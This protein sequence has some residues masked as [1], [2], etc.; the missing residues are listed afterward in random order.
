MNK[1]EAEVIWGSVCTQLREEMDEGPFA[2]WIAPLAPLVLRPESKELVC[3]VEHEFSANWVQTH[4][5]ELINEALTKERPGYRF[6]LETGGIQKVSAPLK[7]EP[8]EDSIPKPKRRRRSVGPTPLVSQPQ[9]PFFDQPDA[10]FTF[11]NFVVGTSNQFAHASA[12]AVAASPGSHYNPLF[13]YSPPGLG[14][15]HLLHAIGNQIRLHQREARL[16]YVSAERFVNEMIDALQHRKMAQ[17]RSKYRDSFDVLL[18]D[19]V[20]FIAGKE[21]S[22]EEFFHTF[23]ALHT[24]KRQIVVSSDRPPKEMT[25]LAERVRTRFESGLIADMTPPNMETRIAILKSKAE[26]DDLYLCDEVASFLAQSCGNNVRELEGMLVRLQAQASLTGAEITIDFAA[27]ELKITRAHSP[28]NMSAMTMVRLVAEF[29]RIKMQDITSLS[30]EKGILL[31]RQVAMY[32]VRKKTGLG[33]REIGS[34]FGGRDHTTVLHACKQV[35]R[36]LENS[37]KFAQDFEKLEGA[38]A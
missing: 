21:T 28:E 26:R 17:F 24:S 30:R 12:V 31:A 25:A 23:N 37:D 22:E 29:Y 35:T 13:I 34:L 32:L 6:V 5:A 33:Y 10:R 1:S 20:Q 19:D 11:D 36:K 3:Q 4:Y 9:K 16:A 15:T 38:L 2:A 27:S 8:S 14:K 7:L 18:M